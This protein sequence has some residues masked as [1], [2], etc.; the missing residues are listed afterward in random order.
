VR[1]PAREPAHGLHLPRV[2]W[3]RRVSS[4]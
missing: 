4:G 1:D 2:A 3:R